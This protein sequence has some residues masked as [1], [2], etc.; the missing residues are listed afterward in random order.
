MLARTRSTVARCAVAGLVAAAI[1][2]QPALA[3][4]RR[5]VLDPEHLAIAFK[6]RHLG[7]SD[8]LGQ[9]LE[10]SGSFVYDEQA[11]TVEDIRVEIQTASVF[12]DHE[13]RDKHVRSGDFLDADDH[14]VITFVSTRAE[15]TGERTGKVY[16]DLT[17]RGV[18]RP[19][20]L[21][22]TLNGAGRYPFGDKHYAVGVSAE[23]TL[24]RSEFGMTYALEGGVVADEVPVMLEFEA[25]R[26]DG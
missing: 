19:V 9:F 5:Y 13:A 10:A 15:P 25:I 7:L 1:A 8:V 12:S 21:D 14:P 17:V 22:V 18:T 26:Q 16:G 2:A 20:V 23:T 6:S 24:K 4:P 3:E 11:R